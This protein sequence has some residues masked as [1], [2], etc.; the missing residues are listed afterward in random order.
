[1]KFM[2][3]IVALLLLSSTASYADTPA[4]LGSVSQG[5][6][7]VMA[8]SDAAKTR[9]EY[10]IQSVYTSKV[11]VPETQL[12]SFNGYQYYTGSGNAT[13]K[14]TYLRT[15]TTGSLWWKKT[16]YVSR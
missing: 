13:L 2:S 10:R 11:Y 8:K 15:E 14:Y 9:G 4:I 3:S 7:Q 6:A 1:M 12:N 16:V 5:S